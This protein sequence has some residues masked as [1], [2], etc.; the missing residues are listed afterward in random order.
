VLWM[1]PEVLLAE[2]IESKLDVYA[3]ALV[4][5]EV[6]TRQDLFSEYTDREI[7]TEDIARKGI[8]P[9]IDKIPPVLKAILIKSWD[10]NPDVRPTFEELI[11]LLR[12]A[13]ID[14][15]LPSTLCPHAGAFWSKN[16]PGKAK[17]PL[18]DFVLKFTKEFNKRALPKEQLACFEALVTEVVNNEALVDIEKFSVLLKCFGPMKIDSANSVLSRVTKVMNQKWFWGD[19]GTIEAQDK[20]ELYKS[21]PG[22]FL[23]RMNMG[24]SVSTDEAPFTITSSSK[25]ASV[26][27][28]IF[29]RTGKPGWIIQI[30]KGKEKVK[31]PTKS[32]DIEVFIAELQAREQTICNKPVPGWPYQNLF[33]DQ[34]A[35]VSTYMSIE[36]ED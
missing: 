23:V 6:L 34:P 17:V 24:G 28:R 8:R 30:K 19:V 12:K 5:W 26:H 7:F 15:F 36:D 3:F 31:I 32:N 20:V 10:R 2:E 13:L 21:E 22:T 33:R 25:Q 27:T 1:A 35:T 18:K 29:R 16:W 9:P 4:M 11:E 14:I